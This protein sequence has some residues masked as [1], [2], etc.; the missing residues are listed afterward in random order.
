VQKLAVQKSL[1]QLKALLNLDAGLP[2][3]IVTPSV[4]GIPV[5]DLATC[6]R[7]LFTILP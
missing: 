6:S 2:F 5:E 4:Q 7:K 3:E 1:L